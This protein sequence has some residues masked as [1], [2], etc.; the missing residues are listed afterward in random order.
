MSVWHGYVVLEKPAVLTGAEWRTV[1]EALSA[2][3]GKADASS[4]PAKRLHGRLSL[5]GTRVLLEAAFDERDLDAEDLGRLCKYVSVALSGKYTPAE[6]REGLRGHVT[7][8]SAGGDWAASGSAARAYLRAHA[9]EW[10]PG[11]ARSPQ[12][13]GGTRS[14]HSTGGTT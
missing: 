2:V 10:E 14:P 4:M 7:L 11:E 3:L 13:T 1:L 5:D 8:F 12:S 6:V 9:Q